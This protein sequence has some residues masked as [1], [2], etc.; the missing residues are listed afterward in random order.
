MGLAIKEVVENGTSVRRAA[1][2]YGLPISTVV[3]NI[4]TNNR[5]KSFHGNTTLSEE[6]E[7][8]LIKHCRSMAALGYGYTAWQVIDLAQNMA[9]LMDPQNKNRS[10]LPGKAWFYYHFTKRHPEFKSI[11]PKKRTASKAALDDEVIQTY[12]EELSKA[13]ESAG[14]T[15]IPRDIWNLDETGISLDHNPPKV[16][17]IILII[18]IILILKMIIINNND[19][20]NDNINNN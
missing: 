19:E 11:K 5:E 15:D 13:M 18:I 2:M 4:K 17:L 1:M 14:V 3:R 8:L 20:Y 16:I 6:Q 10:R 9:L 12:Y 7:L